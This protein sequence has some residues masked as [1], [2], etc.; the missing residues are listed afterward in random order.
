[1]RFSFYRMDPSQIKE[2]PV[3]GSLLPFATRSMPIPDLFQVIDEFD[4][5]PADPPADP[6][7][8]VHQVTTPSAEHSED[9]SRV[10]P[11]IH[12]VTTPS[13]ENREDSSRVPPAGVD[14]ASRIWNNF[15]ETVMPLLG[16]VA[17][18]AVVAN[19]DPDDMTQTDSRK[20]QNDIL[21]SSYSKYLFL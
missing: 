8:A 10:P 15:G 5:T 13:T 2:V 20:I 7:A 3:F 6:Q 19:R 4:E 1:M 14:F 12:Q 17:K 16:G 9:S 11:A 18:A 21:E